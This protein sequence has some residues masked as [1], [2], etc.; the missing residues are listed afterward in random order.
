[1]RR[2]RKKPE[3]RLGEGKISGVIAVLLGGL[4]CLGVLC[5]HYPEYLTTPA[6]RAEYSVPVLRNILQLAIVLALASGAISV[7]LNRRAWLGPTGLT[8]GA[9]ALLAGGSS[10]P[11]PE[12]LPQASLSLGLDWFVLDLLLLA[13]IWIPLERWRPRAPEQLIFRIGWKTDLGY[14][15]MSHL[16]V[17]LIALTVLWPATQVGSFFQSA[18]W[19]ARVSGLPLVV[20]FFGIVWV[21]DLFQYWIHRAFHEFPFLWKFHSVHHSS[22]ELDWLAGS[23]LHLFDI[24]VT[25]A[26]TLLPV[27]ALG[28]SSEAL[29]AYLVFVSLWATLLHA[30][31]RLSWP[32]S[33]ER[34]IAVP[35]VHF[36]HHADHPQA[37]NRNYAIHCSWLD[38]LFGTFCD[39]AGRDPSA[40]GIQRPRQGRK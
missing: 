3:F 29:R 8:L 1:V 15:L 22:R 28:F 9:L 13:L 33:W 12:S 38:R 40:Y 4:S 10:V 34:W 31:V 16:L 23:R 26:F 17:Q 37:L 11:L 20:Q 18:P 24:V 5:F 6:L 36:W 32:P 39:P 7:Y 19:A 35:R 25:R 21:A 2:L 14:F 27:T 30:N